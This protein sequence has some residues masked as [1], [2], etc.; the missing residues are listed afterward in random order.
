M[1]VF[2]LIGKYIIKHSVQLT[3]NAPKRERHI[4]PLLSR[5]NQTNKEIP[6]TTNLNTPKKESTKQKTTK[7]SL[8]TRQPDLEGTKTSNKKN[9]KIHCNTK[10]N[11]TKSAP[12]DSAAN[13]QQ[14]TT[15][16]QPNK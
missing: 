10:I 2:F 12:K 15:R 5:N 6:L 14:S 13:N 8:N 11:T 16:H 1:N 4:Q 3:R 7:R 9:T